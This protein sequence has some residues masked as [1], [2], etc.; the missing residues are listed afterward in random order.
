ME[1]AFISALCKT[2]VQD[3]TANFADALIPT[4]ANAIQW[5]GW[6]VPTGTMQPPHTSP[7]TA[8]SGIVCLK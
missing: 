3:A 5:T 8:T 2:L 7:K 6:S 4:S 1:R